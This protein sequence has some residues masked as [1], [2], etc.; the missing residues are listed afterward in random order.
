MTIVKILI[1]ASIGGIIGWITNYLAIKLMFRPFNEIKVPILNFTFQGL[2]PKRKGEIAKT[3]AFTIEKEL[4]STSELIE[5]MLTQENQQQILH[6]LKIKLTTVVKEKLPP[7]LAMFS[8]AITNMVDSVIEKE[9][10]SI[11]R[12]IM[13]QGGEM[14]TENVQVSTLVEEKINSL[15]LEK[16]EEIILS[17]AKKELKH[18]EILGGVLGFIIGLIQ[19]GIIILIG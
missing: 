11:L 17:I 12:E 3:I 5:N 16:L 2:I 18:I 19:G 7:M 6:F 4:F 15:D 13:T 10:A 8:P 14:L 9:G 1:L